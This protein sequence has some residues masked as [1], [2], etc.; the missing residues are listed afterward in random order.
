VKVGLVYFGG[1]YNHLIMKLLSSLGV[2]VTKMEPMEANLSNFDAVVL[3]GGPQSVYDGGETVQRLSSQIKS[4]SVPLLGICFGHQL[5]AYS[6]GGKVEKSPN[7][8]YGL[9]KI[10]VMEEDTILRGFRDFSAWESHND[11]VVTAP[12]GFITLASSEGA[13]VQAMANPGELKFGVQFHPEV[14][15]TENG[16]RVF[17]NF[18]SAVKK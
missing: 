11:E 8:E 3:S 10:R 17:E 7:P 14:K 9:V 4:T 2:E 15:H 1:Q 6:L 16:V 13:R 18:L 5:L 12:P